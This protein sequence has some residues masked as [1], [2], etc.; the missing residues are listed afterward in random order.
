[1]SYE[2]QKNKTPTQIRYYI[3]CEVVVKECTFVDEQSNGSQ[4]VSDTL[5]ALVP[6]DTTQR[7][8]FFMAWLPDTI[9]EAQELGCEIAHPFYTIFRA[10]LWRTTQH[11]GEIH[12]LV[13]TKATEELLKSFNGAT[14]EVEVLAEDEDEMLDAQQDYEIS[15]KKKYYD[16]DDTEE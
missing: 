12:L 10:A 11:F 5:V 9:L 3:K 7:T 14:V 8:K 15:D 1:M 16:K 2:F 13:M 4:Q 6:Q